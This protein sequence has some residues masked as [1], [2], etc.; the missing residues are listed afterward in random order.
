MFTSDRWSQ[1]KTLLYFNRLR[2]I[3]LFSTF[4]VSYTFETSPQLSLIL[5]EFLCAVPPKSPQRDIT[6]LLITHPN[7][8]LSVKVAFSSQRKNR[9]DPGIE[10]VVSFFSFIAFFTDDNKHNSSES[11]RMRRRNSWDTENKKKKTRTSK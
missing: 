4:L 6:Q 7:L 2:S 9:V 5:F 11:L 3:E 8:Q 1:K 10:L